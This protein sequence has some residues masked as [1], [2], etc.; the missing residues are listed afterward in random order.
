MA[1]FPSLDQVT[2]PSDLPNYEEQILAYWDE[3]K[4][5]QR[6]VSERPASKPFVFYDG[7]PFVTGS[8]HYGS[9][10]GSIA[11]DVVPRYWTMKGYRVERQWGWDCHGLPIEN[12]IEKEL[13]LKNGKR[14][15]EEF[16]IA[17]FNNACR[18][19]IAE[20]DA[21]WEVI[22][23]R[24]GRWVD[25][26][27]SYKTMDTNYME[28]VW[29]A[30][31][32]LWQKELVYQGRKVMLY[33]PRCATPLSN[34]EI[35]MD[36]SYVDVKEWG[37]TYKFEI[38]PKTYA[39]AWSTTPW[40]KIGTMALA[41]HPELTYAVVKQGDETYLL[42]ESRLSEL[43]DTPYE[44]LKTLSGKE[45]VQEFS[46]PFTPHFDWAGL[47]PEE[48]T[49]AYRLV[50]DE[51]VT[52]D[53]GT[54]IVTLA[55]Y[56]ED[57]YRVMK[58]QNIPLYDYVDEN[59]R[60]DQT[61][62]NLEWAG[63]SLLKVN[64]AIDADLTE[65]GLVYK[66]EPHTHSVATCYRCNTRLYHAPL[67]AWFIDV[68]KIKPKL[69]AHNEPINWYPEHLKYGRFGN[70]LK[71]APDWNI[72]R[73]RY[74]GTPMPIWSGVSDSGEEQMRIIGSIEELKQ[75]AVD[76]TQVAA[77]TDIHR[78]FVD[79][80]EIWVDEAKTVRGR[81]V[82]EVFDVWIESGSMPFAAKHYPFEKKEEFEAAYPA[83]FISEYIAQTRAW[84]YTLHVLSVGLFDAPSFLNVLTSGVIT[85]ADGQ[86]MSKSKKNYTDP[87]LLINSQGADALRL[88]L[89]ASPVMKAENLA[90]NDTDVTKLRQRVLN[91]WWNVVSFYRMYQ[92]AGWTPSAPEPTNVIDRWMIARINAAIAQI[93]TDFDHYNVAD[94]S[95]QIIDVVGDLSTWYLRQSRD[96][97]RAGDVPSWNT[98]AWILQQ[99]SL[100]AAPVVPFIAEASFHAVDPQA[101]SVHLAEWPTASTTEQDA[102]L[103]TE[104][105][106]ARKV[107]EAGH[108]QR[109]LLGLKVRQPLATA[110]VT[111]ARLSAEVTEI[112][113]LEL[114]VKA[115]DFVD[116]EQ[117]SVT[118]DTTITPELAAESQA[119]ELVRSIQQLRRESGTTV[120]E[121]VEVTAPTWPT[122]WESYI[123]ERAKISRLVVGPELLVTRRQ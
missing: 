110:T 28:S 119:R 52:A 26:K 121:L 91:M 18:S 76:P 107:V 30:F 105:D 43:N 44:V 87:L 55:I 34:F 90:F 96:R 78:E 114:N 74:W 82:P 112:V 35:A 89:M 108:A 45:A 27:N 116:R 70:G 122:A 95:R 80:I 61:I 31:Q 2:S 57:D 83:Q 9:I 103:L 14:G 69:I 65:R 79:D 25:F 113:A 59:G 93:S 29:W 123:M 97:L 77:L 92:P 85:A 72:S 88:Y 106:L 51:F 115:V 40:T 7:P 117:L 84:F 58:E 99:L 15:I 66:R 37:T 109:K 23:R 42:A 101:D 32:Q 81:R 38:L 118:L 6:S 67:P 10:L 63:Q 94:A 12:M 47:T 36:N 56:G 86:K 11:K 21:T 71:S 54:G 16:G 4:A 19:A 3:I 62:Q 33:C 64:D 22:I 48:R 68:Q 75:W 5:F 111:G 102:T 20:L 104:M 1:T 73:S 98:F 24:I 39:L 41:L 8:P 100:I 46:N 49:R 50:T 13:G 53:T 17:N 120:D 60:L